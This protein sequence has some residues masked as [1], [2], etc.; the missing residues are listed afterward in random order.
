MSFLIIWYDCPMCGKEKS[1]YD[2]GFCGTCKEK[3]RRELEADGAFMNER[4][5]N[6]HLSRLNE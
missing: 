3:H 5:M 6:E 4:E 2:D 1:C